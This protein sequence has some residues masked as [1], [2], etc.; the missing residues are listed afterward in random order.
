M[1][2]LWL[3]HF[4]FGRWVGEMEYIGRQCYHHLTI[5]LNLMRLAPGFLAMR[6]L[7]RPVVGLADARCSSLANMVSTTDEMLEEAY[8]TR[9]AH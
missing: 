6:V 3:C 5:R 9:G 1:L 2:A 7:G 8:Q 4:S